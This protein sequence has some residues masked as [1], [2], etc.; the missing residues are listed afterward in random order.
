VPIQS[1]QYKKYHEM[2]AWFGLAA[3]VVV[4]MT[5]VLERTVWRKLP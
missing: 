3:F 2:Y 1:F 5:F 4:A